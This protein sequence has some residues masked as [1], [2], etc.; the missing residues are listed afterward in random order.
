MRGTFRRGETRIDVLLERATAGGSQCTV[1]V[2]ERSHAIDLVAVDGGAVTLRI[3]GKLVRAFVAKDGDR[4]LV[5]VV[6]GPVLEFESG[7]AA[8]TKKKHGASG[9]DALVATMHGQVVKVNVK[10]GDTVKRGDALVVLEAM[11]MEMRL[12]APHDGVVRAVHC[13]EG[14][15][16]ERGKVLVE[17]G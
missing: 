2:G 1:R 9:N 7:D 11:K 14:E 16:V 15:V 13:R 10:A 3:A 6:G 8:R 5:R 17:V 12:S 4:R